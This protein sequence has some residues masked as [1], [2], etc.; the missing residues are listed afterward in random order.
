MKKALIAFTL[1]TSLGLISS[2]HAGTQL[3]KSEHKPQEAVKTQ[4]IALNSVDVKTLTHKVKGIG[5]ARAKAIV[6]YRD[7][8]G[9]Y[10]SIDDLSRVPGI[11]RRTLARYRD[12][13]QKSFTMEKSQ[14]R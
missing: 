9:R 14:S 1:F 4:P 3:Q 2:G 12:V 5:A 8:H 13:W 6:A 11:S 10:K 7:A